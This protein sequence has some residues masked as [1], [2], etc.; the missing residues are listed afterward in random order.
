[1]KT[2]K[3]RAD[4][5]KFALGK[6]EGYIPSSLAVRSISV[7]R[8]AVRRKISRFDNFNSVSSKA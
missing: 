3:V 6:N 2:A 4:G 1:M 7:E 5:N 8:Q